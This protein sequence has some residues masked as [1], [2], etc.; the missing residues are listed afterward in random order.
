MLSSLKCQSFGRLTSFFKST[1]TMYFWC[2]WRILILHLK[3]LHL[4]IIF[5]T[6][7]QGMTLC[8]GGMFCSGALT[9]HHLPASIVLDVFSLVALKYFSCPRFIFNQLHYNLPRNCSHFAFDVSNVL[10]FELVFTF[11]VWKLLAVIFSNVFF[12]LHSL[13]RS[14]LT[15]LAHPCILLLPQSVLSALLTIAS[16]ALCLQSP[17]SFLWPSSTS[18]CVLLVEGIY[19]LLHHPVS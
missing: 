13:F 11:K 1:L 8:I 19:F 2:L 6:L 12:C 14:S 15:L 16:R 5:S 4:A 9:L 7:P 3:W 10:I 18:L 17:L